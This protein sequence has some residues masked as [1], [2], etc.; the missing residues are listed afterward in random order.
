MRND[1]KKCC[2]CGEYFDGWGNNP[3]PVKKRGDCCDLCNCFIVI[4]ARIE[5]H[6]KAQTEYKTAG[7]RTL[8]GGI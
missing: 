2:I 6:S 1:I 7:I 4:P 3:W 8:K 5:L